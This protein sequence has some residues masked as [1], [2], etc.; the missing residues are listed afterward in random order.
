MFTKLLTITGLAS[1]GINY[2]VAAEGG[3]AA[4]QTLTTD[5][6]KAGYVIGANVGRNLKRQIGDVDS[7]AFMQGIKDALD[8]A[9]LKFSDEEAQKIMQTFQDKMMAEEKKKADGAI[10]ASKA[11]LE[12]NGQKKGVTTTPTGLQFEITKEGTGPKPTAED[13]VKVHY[14]GTLIDGTVFDSSVERGE[15]IEFPLNGV[16]KGWTEG[17]QLMPTGSKFKFTIPSDLAYGPQGSPPKIP[18][19]AALVFDVELIAIV[20]GEPEPESK[21]KLKGKGKQAPEDK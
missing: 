14:H 2:A 6:Q 17:V 13:T 5:N 1:V 16:I 18:G 10:A 21:P 12:K 15:P 8:G 3:G 20:K 4:G 7:A 11:F 9:K 19:G